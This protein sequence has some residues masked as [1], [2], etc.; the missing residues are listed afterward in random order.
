MIRVAIIDDQELVRCG[1]RQ[2]LSSQT[3]IDVVAEGATSED[4]IH[5][6]DQDRPDVMLLDIN[7]QGGPT[8][9][10]AARILKSRHPRMRLM[11]LSAC[12]YEVYY[13]RLLSLGCLNYATKDIDP[14]LFIQAVRDVY[15]G[16][17]FVDPKIE[18]YLAEQ[19]KR[20]ND[21]NPFNSLT[22]RELEIAK[23]FWADCSAE[24]IAQQLHLS[25]RTVYTHKYKIY[26]KLGLSS[27]QGPISL[28]HMALR[29]GLADIHELP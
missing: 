17:I 12:N 25:K 11:A 3:D 4:A 29:Y 15:C 6:A 21:S 13:P 18:A 2:L 1:F 14:R 20:T 28:Y 19:K 26:E 24:A 5:I 8:G 22:E 9:V 23:M 10:N 7:L 27:D 16:K